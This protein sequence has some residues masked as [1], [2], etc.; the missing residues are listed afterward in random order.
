MNSFRSLRPRDINLETAV[1]DREAPLH[2]HLFHAAALNTADAAFAQGYENEGWEKIS[3]VEVPTRALS[4]LLDQHL[5]EGM[6]IHLL[7]LDVEG[8]EMG[9][10]RSRDW[11]W[12]RTEIIIIEVLVCALPTLAE[13]PSIRFL[14][15]RGYTLR[16]RLFNSVV[17][18]R[19]VS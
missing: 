10:L 2:V 19:E 13:Q 9:V 17:L 3:E 6:P 15:E 1:S 7:S 18:M 8:E 4:S 12:C 16:Y 5:P 11:E 14:A